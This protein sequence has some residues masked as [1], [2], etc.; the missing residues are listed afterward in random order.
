MKERIS[1]LGPPRYRQVTSG[2]I[3][4]RDFTGQAQRVRQVIDKI[5]SDVLM[6]T[7][8]GVK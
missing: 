5:S 4:L 2:Q 6:P 8:E 1:S 7:F 3:A